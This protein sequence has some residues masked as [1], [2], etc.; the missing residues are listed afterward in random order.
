MN[1][2]KDL[3]IAAFSLGIVI[4]CAMDRRKKLHKTALEVSQHEWETKGPDSEED[5]DKEVESNGDLG[6]ML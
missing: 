3:I 4:S 6:I 2:T 1:G 5:F